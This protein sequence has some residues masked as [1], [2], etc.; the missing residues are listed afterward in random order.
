MG[1]RWVVTP[2]TAASS[3]L[4]AGPAPTAAIAESPERT[5]STIW[6]AVPARRSTTWSRRDGRI[7]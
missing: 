5:E 3:A 6:E 4:V 1:L 2:G 7:Q